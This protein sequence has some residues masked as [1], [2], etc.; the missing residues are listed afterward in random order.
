MQSSLDTKIEQQ[1]EKS[2]QVYK[3]REERKY[4]VFEPTRDAKK[5]EDLENIM[6]IAR[7]V[8]CEE[9]KVESFFRLGKPTEGKTRLVNVC[10]DSVTRKHKMLGGTK[11]LYE[12]EDRDYTSVWSM[13]SSPKT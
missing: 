3:E 4:N 9:I 12:K 2:L 1:V 10:L 11:V 7:S 13:F 5:K 8:K 6:K